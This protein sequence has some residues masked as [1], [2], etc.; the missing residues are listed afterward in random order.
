M[1]AVLS[2]GALLAPVALQ[3]Q[4]LAP[5]PEPRD[6]DYPGVIALDVD[7]T[8][9]DQRV[10]RTQMLLTV[11]PGPMVLLYPRWL[12]GNHAPTGP[13]ESLAGL[14]LHARDARG[15]RRRLD[16]RRHPL[17]MYAFELTVP[18]GTKTLEVA[19]QFTTPLAPEQGRRVITPEILGLQWEKALLYPA[20]HYISR[21]R[22]LPVI[23]LRPGWNYGAALRET[24]RITVAQASD[25][26]S[27]THDRV[28]FAEVTLERLVDSPLFAGRHYK[29]F[30]LDPLPRAPAHLHVFADRPALLE[31]QPAQIEA[32][33]KLV[34]EAVTLFASR[35]Y[36]RYEFTL[37]HSHAPHAHTR[38]D[39]HIHAQPY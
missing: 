34:R 18:E 29:R 33:R 6:V 23:R 26:N 4:A 31:T 7:L 10:I 37:T 39:A 30:E 13:I 27:M 1:A 17:N 12:P 11:S 24:S 19:L 14:V 5:T 21:I 22:V 15:E 25:A 28:E 3:A 8:D 9:L 32:H 38:C 16:W 35:H 20:G 2:V 36:T